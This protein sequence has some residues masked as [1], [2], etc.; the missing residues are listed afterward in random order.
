MPRT[1]I[2]LWVSA[3]MAL[4]AGGCPGL[5][6]YANVDLPFNVNEP[7]AAVV[8]S[9]EPVFQSATIVA[10]IPGKVGH[11]APTLTAFDDGE[12]LAAWYSYDGPEELD[13][14]AIYT[15]RRR[16]GAEQWE[17]P[18]LCID[19]S[20]AVGNPVLYSE[21][22]EVWLFHA[23]IPGT[24]W[25][26]A[27][28][29]LQRSSTRG[30]T[31]SAPRVIAAP[32]GA[33]VR[34]P[35]VRRRDGALLLPAYDDLLPRSLFLASTDGAAWT[36]VSLLAADPTHPSIQPSLVAL[37]DGRLLA[38]M[39][40]G[41]RGW[42]WASAS[43]D[44]GQHWAPPIDSGFPNPGSPATLLRLGSGRLVLVYNDSNETRSPLSITISADE[45][46]TWHPPRVLVAGS[47]SYAYPTAVQTPDGLIHIVY[48][49]HR[50]RIE[51]IELN[52]AWIVSE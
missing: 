10:S 6:P 24:G 19:R 31:W 26:T 25:S 41:G 49:H 30:R 35:P 33:N 22:D 5:I 39:R 2:L 3:T 21:G 44:N 42:L 27:H 51:H 15:A 43:D 38:V 34:F 17:P 16:T 37:D 23:V 46:R 18:R 4:L 48:S 9:G 29:E 14:A 20:E 28:I 12:L 52:E 7:P 13:G 40:N 47:G 45:G 50:A 8:V 32:L 11:H 1:R 36:L